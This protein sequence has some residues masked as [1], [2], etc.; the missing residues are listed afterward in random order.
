MY[1]S[2]I[3]NGSVDILLNCK[4]LGWKTTLDKRPGFNVHERGQEASPKGFKERGGDAISHDQIPPK[5]PRPVALGL[6]IP[7]PNPG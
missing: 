6:A 2:A 4:S 3:A 7:Y 1:R 5:N